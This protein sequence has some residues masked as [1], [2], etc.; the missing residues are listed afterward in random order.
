M[1]IPR[2]I[3]FWRDGAAEEIE[4]AAE[5]LKKKRQRHALFF[6][7]LA[8]EKMLKALVVKETKEV[9]PKIHNLLVLSRLAGLELPPAMDEYL[10]YF[11]LWNLEGRYPEMFDHPIDPRL[12][13]RQMGVAKEILAWLNLQF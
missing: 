9:P 11:N 4:V 2:Q 10:R 13:K 3:N 12:A 8:V 7:H 1:D 6:A 5:L